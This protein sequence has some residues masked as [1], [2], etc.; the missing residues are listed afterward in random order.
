VLVLASIQDIKFAGLCS[1][2]QT[3]IRPLFKGAL[4]A[5][6]GKGGGGRSFFQGQFERAEILTDFLKSLPKKIEEAE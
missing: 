5:R 1:R 6:G 2:K 3:D 4:E